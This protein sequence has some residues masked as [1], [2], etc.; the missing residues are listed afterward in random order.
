[1]L[2]WF[3]FHEALTRLA[4]IFFT[5]I[6]TVNFDLIAVFVKVA[7]QIVKR[8]QH[9]VSPWC[10][11]FHAFQNCTSL[12][13][14]RDPS[15]TSYHHHHHHHHCALIP[16]SRNPLLVPDDCIQKK[17]ITNLPYKVRRALVVKLDPPRELG[18]DFKHLA[19]EM[20]FT[21]DQILY[22]K[23]LK[24]PTETVLNGC[25]SRSIE[26]LC[27]KLDVIGRGDA[28]LEIDKWVKTQDCK[29]ALCATTS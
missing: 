8:A 19:D 2:F 27:N 25:S 1:M 24:N 18:G 3:S 15:S 20:G 11:Y 29:C 12:P 13:A 5:W 28:R 6:P 9:F 7:L 14:S 16:G 22:F 21:T 23:S 10:I 4:S 26:D 17:F